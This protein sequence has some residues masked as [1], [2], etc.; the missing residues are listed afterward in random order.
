MA[1]GGDE[2]PTSRACD[3]RRA[4]GATR[5]RGGGARR[6][7]VAM[8][9]AVAVAAARVGASYDGD[10]DD[11]DRR[12]ATTLDVGGDAEYDEVLLRRDK[13]YRFDVSGTSSDVV[14]ELERESGIPLVYLKKDSSSTGGWQRI[15]GAYAAIGKSNE[16]WDF[17]LNRYTVGNYGAYGYVDDYRTIKLV[18]ASAGRY[19]LRVKNLQETSMT[20]GRVTYSDVA[21]YKL[22]VR[23][24][25]D[26]VTQ[27]PLCAWDCSSRGTC[28][29]SGSA[30][31][32]NTKCECD[33]SP[34]ITGDGFTFASG[35]ACRDRYGTYE[36]LRSKSSLTVSP[37]QFLYLS[38]DAW[39]LVSRSQDY[40]LEIDVYWERGGDPLLLVKAG[41]PPTL[42]DYDAQYGSLRLGYNSVYLPRLASSQMYY[43]A[44]FN[45]KFD[46]NSDCVFRISL[47]SASRNRATN[48]PNMVSMALVLFVSM[49][50]C[51]V[52]ALI[53]RYFQRR[54]LTQFREQRVQQLSMEELRT[55][56][57]NDRNTNPGT[58]EDI[59]SQIALVDY[60]PNLKDG[61]LADGQE[62]TCTICLDD[63]VEGDK[64]RRFP[65]C[66]HMFHQECADLWLHT[67]HTCPNCRA[68]LLPEE[69]APAAE[70]APTAES[71]PMPPGVPGGVYELAP[72]PYALR[73]QAAPVVVVHMPPPPTPV[74]GAG[75]IAPANP[76]PFDSSELPT[77]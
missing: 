33:A 47:T 9:V 8:A 50:F 70:S 45:R 46:A 69:N 68:S 76:R 22:R 42:I 21:R 73:G 5:R 40:G 11:D 31:G 24:T 63:Y 4:R 72:L 30:T 20:T 14:V 58:P 49:S 34:T 39:N 54:Y 16:W 62:P 43:F 75:G 32:D 25:S 18:G 66:K 59:I 35:S 55:Q 6:A 29:N 3:A 2:A 19:Y 36:N 67:S 56:R 15:V 12:G 38:Y 53:K 57:R 23:S 74:R 64:L 17:P 44:V 28:V 65:Q 26:G 77:I 52:V 27:A 1:P 48:S 71:A 7:F 10:D 37:G 51:F 13:W 41:S 60:H 61:I